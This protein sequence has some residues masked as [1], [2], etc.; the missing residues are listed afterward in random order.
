[1]YN[2]T[3]KNEKETQVPLLPFGET[4]RP[5]ILT[6]SLSDTDIKFVLQKRGIF[7]KDRRKGNTIPKLTSILLS[8]REFDILKNR[9]QFKESAI[10]TSDAKT[11][12]NSEKTIVQAFPEECEHLANTLIDEASSYELTQCAVQHGHANEVIVNCSIK[13]RDWTKDVF[14]QTTYHDCALSITR[15]PESKIVTYH[16][17]TTAPE[18]REFMNKLQTAIHEKF[19]E[20]GVVS[21][22]TEIQKILANHFVNN[23]VRFEFLHHFIEQ[24]EILS[25]QKIVDIDVGI[26]RHFKEFPKQFRWLKGNIDTISLHGSRIHETDVM[27]LG[28]IGVF[29]FGEIEAEF[30]FEYPEAKGTCSI[31]YG[32][33]KYYEKEKNIEFE[34]KIGSKLILHPN[35]AHVSKKVVGNFLLKHFQKN[36]HKLFEQF[37]A[38]NKVDARKRNFENQYEFLFNG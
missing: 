19:Q 16:M 2:D 38:E 33:P 25:F 5:L 6:S 13:R 22:N 28:K 30:K 32:F 29:V 23:Q 37:K 9:Q 17:E 20:S 10:K 21:Q 4:L 35:Y 27:Q 15:E 24:S 1:M 14:S 8:P 18:T 7:V 12:W 26:D 34:A 11:N 31:Q 3:I 36:K